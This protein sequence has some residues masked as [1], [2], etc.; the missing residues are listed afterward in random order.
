ESL[1][2]ADAKQRLLLNKLLGLHRQYLNHYLGRDA[3]DAA[4]RH[5]GYVEGLIPLS[6]PYPA[7]LATVVADGVAR[8]REELATDFLTATREV[9]KAGDVP[10][11]WR[12]NYERG[13]SFLR[14]LLSL[15]RDNLRLLTALV[16]ICGDW[17]LDCYNNEDPQTLW[18]QVER[19]TPFA[20]KLARLVD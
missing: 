6:A 8:F 15:D 12:A 10:E 20:F 13:L 4:R 7:A 1:G 3:V 9:L 5:W 16:D 11:G 14:R 2:S 17:F 18:E 19:F